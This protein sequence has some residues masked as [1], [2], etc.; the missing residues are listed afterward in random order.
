MVNTKHLNYN[1]NL[2]SENDFTCG[3]IS[4]YISN[5]NSQISLKLNYLKLKHIT[6]VLDKLPKYVLILL[7]IYI[8]HTP[9][10]VRQN[11]YCVIHSKA[12]NEEKYL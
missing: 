6:V 9:Y 10:F 5:N 8:Y 11:K 2:V 4:L 7:P 12:Q 1:L 3:R